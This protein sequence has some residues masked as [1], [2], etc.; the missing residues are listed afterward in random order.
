MKK[1]TTSIRVDPELLKAAR[2]ANLNVS[3]LFRRALL[4][5]LGRT[6]TV[7]DLE[8]LRLGVIRQYQAALREENTERADRMARLVHKLKALI[9]MHQVEK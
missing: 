4:E 3:G 7:K 8:V 6:L 9:R 2:S 5:K 1:E